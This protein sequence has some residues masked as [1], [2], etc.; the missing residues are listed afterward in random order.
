MKARV[1][2][3]HDSRSPDFLLQEMGSHG[4]WG[5][6]PRFCAP[7]CIPDR[8]LSPRPSG[9]LTTAH[10]RRRWRAPLDLV[11]TETALRFLK[12]HKMFS[13]PGALTSL[14]SCMERSGFSFSGGVGGSALLLQARRRSRAR[15]VRHLECIRGP[16]GA[17]SSVLLHNSF[18]RTGTG[19]TKASGIQ[20]D[21]PL[22]L[23]AFLP[24]LSAAAVHTGCLKFAG[25]R[26]SGGQPLF[27]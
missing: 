15:H 1:G 5:P 23:S 10:A 11:P 27:L 8:C 12:F 19:F 7:G 25:N 3:T 17:R 14:V 24:D 21:P 18:R 26:P 9:L 16:A 13:G 20:T 22:S 6:A 2:H 4:G